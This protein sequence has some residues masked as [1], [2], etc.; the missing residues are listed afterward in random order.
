MGL[1]KRLVDDY[2]MVREFIDN[3]FKPPELDIGRVAGYKEVDSID[4][5][6]SKWS[7]KKETVSFDS[8]GQGKDWMDPNFVMISYSLSPQE[9]KAVDVVLYEESNNGDH[10]FTITWPRKNG[11][12]VEPT[13]IYIKRAKHF[14]SKMQALA[15]FLDDEN[16]KKY[17]M[18]GNF[19]AHAVETAFAREKLTVPKINNYCMDI[20]AAA[21][22]ID[23]NMFVMSSL[24]ELQMAFTD[25][26]ED[27]KSEFQKKYNIADMLSVPKSVRSVYSCGD[28]D[29]T[30]RVGFSI[31][32]ELVKPENRSVARYLV[33]FTMPA[34]GF[35]R[36]LETNGA[37][38]DRKKLPKVTIDVYRSMIEE[39]DKA[40]SFI[41]RGILRDFDIGG[42]VIKEARKN[43][44]FFLTRDELVSEVL[45]GRHGFSIPGIK[46]TASK[47]SWSVAKEVRIALLDGDLPEEAREFI[48]AYDEFS[49][50]HSM[51]SRYLKGFEKNI[52]GDGRIH[53]SYSLAVSAERSTSRNPNMQNNPKRSKMAM[54]I[55]ELICAPP[56]YL[57]MATDGKHSELRWAA[58][59]SGDEELMR[60]FL[61]DRDPHAEVALDFLRRKDHS[62]TIE[63]WNGLSS[64]EIELKRRS[65]K[66]TNFGLLFG[67]GAKG[68]VRY[69]RKDYGLKMTEAEATEWRDAWFRKFKG[70]EPYRQK[71]IQIGLQKGYVESVLGRRRRLPELKSKDAYSRG[72]AERQAAHHPIASTSSDTIMLCGNESTKEKVDPKKVR[73]TLFVHDELVYE[74]KENMVDKWKDMMKYHMEN[75][76]LERDFNYKMRVP[77][78]AEVK[79]GEN[80]ASLQGV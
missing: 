65:A 50:A 78:S 72:F 22:I 33:K 30:R 32:G 29:V 15:K 37:L 23:E 36:I 35:L 73:P 11:K 54:M 66:C 5:L 49:D 16:I 1:R 28:A 24:D 25:V 77:L 8:E 53:S 7:A 4:S 13:T 6:L 9:G 20:Q 17:M 3:D 51:W 10:D 12:K 55:R 47:E 41:P 62:W 63:R 26:R 57:L 70:I 42:S 14:H 48:L 56:G 59:Y 69:A 44:K 68:L 60:I 34:L 18:Y 21:N 58:E 39:E 67:M 19:D 31:K 46:K 38:I 27:Y 52:K 76:P 71:M 80:L 40:I 43:E 64:R 75:P 74:V 45:F 79:V 61:E 2:K